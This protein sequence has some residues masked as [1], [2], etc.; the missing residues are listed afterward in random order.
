MN[1]FYKVLIEKIK[2][3]EGIV[4][5][6]IIETQGSAPQVPGAS[7]LFSKSGLLRGTLGG[8]ILEATAQKKANT[9]LE[10]GQSK[11]LDFDLTSE[12]MSAEE[13]ICGGRVKVLIDG[14]PYVHLEAFKNLHQSQKERASGILATFI[15]RI[16]EKD[17]HIKREWIIQ[18]DIQQSDLD[19]QHMLF[20]N[21]LQRTLSEGRPSLLKIRE[22]HFLE[23]G[24]DHWLYLE[25]AVPYPR[26]VIAGAGHVGQAVAHLGR[27]LQFEVTVIDDRA[28]FANI[29]RIPDADFFLIENIPQA[30][31]NFPICQDTYIVIAT[32]DHSY[33]KETLRACISSPA[34]YIGM[35]GSRRKVKL[36]RKALLEEG[37]SS[38]EKFDRIYTPIGLEIHSKT[39]EEIAVSIAAQLV[40]VR[41]E[42]K[43]KE[44]NK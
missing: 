7:A 25:P 36:I 23:K 30:V 3:N 35:I 1:H 14:S 38:A 28:E 20:K 37:W 9:A 27:L 39:V 21:E 6:T 29:D 33:D 16:S 10:D 26:L 4:L 41:S 44:R 32:R 12:T 22:N 18:K 24:I 43:E 2:H 40:L 8:G 31:G 5:A 19:A 42:K 34:A 11:I 15:S 17:S 13:A